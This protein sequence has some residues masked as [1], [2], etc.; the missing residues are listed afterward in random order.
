MIKKKDL[1]P[2]AA[3]GLTTG[4]RVL[5][6]TYRSTKN[7][8]AAMSKKRLKTSMRLFP[9]SFLQMVSLCRGPNIH[10]CCSRPLRA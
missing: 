1:I 9:K 5:I 10:D 8:P 2:R 7:I 4:F 3:D 6:S